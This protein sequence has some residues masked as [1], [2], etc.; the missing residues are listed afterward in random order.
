VLR[1]LARGHGL[2]PESPWFPAGITARS[3]CSFNFLAARAI[4]A[5]PGSTPLACPQAL[6]TLASVFE[7]ARLRTGSIE[8]HPPEVIYVMLFGLGLVRRLV[9][10]HGAG[11]GAEKAD[12]VLVAH[13]FGTT[14][15][16]TGPR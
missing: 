16:S 7:V 5:C 9:L 8:K 14:G 15:G 1:A 6:P 12:A 11:Q 3:C 10:R 4:A 2:G 13:C